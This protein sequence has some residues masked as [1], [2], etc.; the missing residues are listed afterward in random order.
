MLLKFIEYIKLTVGFSFLCRILN[1][2]EKILSLRN[3]IIKSLIQGT[4]KA[5]K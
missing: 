4:L 1:Y 3:D 5:H 2:G